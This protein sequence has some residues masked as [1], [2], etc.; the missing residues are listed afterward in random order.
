MN[1]DTVNDRKKGE[2]EK[3]KGMEGAGNR[4]EGKERRNGDKGTMT[5]DYRVQRFL[6]ENSKVSGWLASPL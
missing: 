6:N 1:F 5:I 4:N 3:E 2:K